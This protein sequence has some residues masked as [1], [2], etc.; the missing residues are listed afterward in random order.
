MIDK[1]QAIEHHRFDG[2]TDREVPH[3]WIVLGRLIE[4]LAAAKF[5]EHASH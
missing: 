3:C 4:H 5:L 1:S 2:L